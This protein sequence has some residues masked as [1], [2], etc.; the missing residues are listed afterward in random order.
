MNEFETM[1]TRYVRDRVKWFYKIKDTDNDVYIDNIITDAV[2]EFKSYKK[3]KSEPA[4]FTTDVCDNKATLPCNYKS[5]IAVVPNCNNLNEGEFD[6]GRLPLVYVNSLQDGLTGYFT[7]CNLRRNVFT[8]QNGYIQFPEGTNH[9]AVDIYCE[10]Y[11]QD[12]N[13][14][15]IIMKTHYPYVRAYTMYQVGLFLA[16]PRY[17]NFANFSKIGQNIITNEISDKFDLGKHIFRAT[18]QQLITVNYAFQG[19]YPLVNNSAYNG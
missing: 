3:I 11:L 13:G 15:P 19:N 12:E 18:I 16:D 2:N 9:E 14:M 6:R 5:V 4:P 17:K 8:I 1:P 10:V 7:G